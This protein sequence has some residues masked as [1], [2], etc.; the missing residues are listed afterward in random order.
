MP[1][2]PTG[3]VEPRSLGTGSPDTLTTLE[4]R[5]IFKRMVRDEMLAGTLPYSRRKDLLRYAE[6]IGLGPVH[7]NLLIYEARRET[8]VELLDASAI[9]PSRRSGPGMIRWLVW[10][11]IGLVIAAV[12]YL[13]TLLRRILS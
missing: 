12:A 8:E 1:I 13:H 6:Q 2:P 3:P 9:L 7:A 4:L 10:L 11:Q 5:V